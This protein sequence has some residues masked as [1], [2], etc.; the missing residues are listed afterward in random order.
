MNF[1]LQPDAL[2]FS[3]RDTL[4]ER[5]QRV[6]FAESCTGGLLAKRATDLAGSSDWFECG[7]VTYSNQAKSMLLGVRAELIAAVGA[8]S[9]QCAEAMAEGALEHSISD[10]AVGVTGI[11][12]PGGGSIEKPVGTVWIAWQHRGEAV[13]SACFRFSGDRDAVRNQ[14]ADAALSGLIDRLRHAG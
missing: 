2:M 6:A 9:Q 11:A 12:G 10:W 4:L 3:L 8:V 14:S 5:A 1:S 13:S 7:F